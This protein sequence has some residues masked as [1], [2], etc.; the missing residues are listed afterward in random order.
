MLGT[1]Q[2]CQDQMFL[3]SPGEVAEMAADPENFGRC[4]CGQY[5]EYE[6]VDVGVGV[7]RGFDCCPPPTVAEMAGPRC[8]KAEDCGLDDGHVHG[9]DTP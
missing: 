4:R 7:I 1:C 2:A 5:R 3:P 6:R 8:T 9:C